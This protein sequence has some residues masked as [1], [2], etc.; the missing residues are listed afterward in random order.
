MKSPQL[1][2]VGF[3]FKDMDA[4]I[5]AAFDGGVRGVNTAPGFALIGAY[6]D[7]S[8]ARLA[9]LQ[10]KGQA[11]NV[12]AGLRS[13][14]T[15]R[16]QVIRFTDVLARVALYS[17]GEDGKLMTQFLAM[18]D[19]PIA[20]EQH[21]LG[22]GGGFSIIQALQ[23]GA[24]AMEVEVFEDEAAFTASDSARVGPMLMEPKSMAS[25]ALMGLQAASLTVEEATPTLLMGAVVESVEVRRNE[26]SEV[27]F[28][29]VRASSTVDLTIAV[30]MEHPVEPGNVIHGTFYATV[31]AGTWD[32]NA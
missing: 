14:T 17:P 8:G 22:P 27:N 28:Q 3:D 32:N 13:E 19:D 21:D 29:Y 10:R 6:S 9:F 7:P 11:A 5:K 25:P 4:L 16:A 30:P 15:Y 26:L 18:V 1:H 23:V 24:L 20:Y 12:S 31:N 2:A